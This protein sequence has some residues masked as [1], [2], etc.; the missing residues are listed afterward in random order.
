MVKG[1]LFKSSFSFMG[2]ATCFPP[3]TIVRGFDDGCDSVSDPRIFLLDLAKEAFK[4]YCWPSIKK[5]TMYSMLSFE[6]ETA[7]IIF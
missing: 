5:L 1:G 7:F 6:V 4:W 3:F 2:L